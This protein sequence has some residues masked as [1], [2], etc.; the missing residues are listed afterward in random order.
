MRPETTDRLLRLVEE[1]AGELAFAAVL[2]TFVALLLGIPFGSAVVVEVA[3]ALACPC[4][5]EGAE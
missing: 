2:L 1:N 3:E 4:A 5:V